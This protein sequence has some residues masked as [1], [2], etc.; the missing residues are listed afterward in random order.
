MREVKSKC[1]AD[2]SPNPGKNIA[3]T[4]VRRDPILSYFSRYQASRFLLLV[5]RLDVFVCTQIDNMTDL[6]SCL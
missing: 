6:A 2:D 4:R 5:S 1:A 3:S